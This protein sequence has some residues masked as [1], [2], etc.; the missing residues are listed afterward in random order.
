MTDLFVEAIDQTKNSTY[1]TTNGGVAE[2]PRLG[3]VPP[4]GSHIVYTDD[5]FTARRRMYVCE[6]VM[7]DVEVVYAPGGVAAYLLH[8]GVPLACLG[9]GTNVAGFNTWGNGR[10]RDL[11]ILLSYVKGDPS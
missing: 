9:E 8:H 10:K 1:I 7:Y 3:V 4:I 6:D 5:G 2:F 11:D